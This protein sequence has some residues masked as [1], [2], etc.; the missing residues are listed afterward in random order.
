MT[1]GLGVVGLELAVVQDGTGEVEE[2]CCLG[3][4]ARRK[5]AAEHCVVLI[6]LIC[7]RFQCLRPAW[8][9]FR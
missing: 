4:A 1:V 8:M 2:A 3:L 7:V 5:S 9:L 6:G